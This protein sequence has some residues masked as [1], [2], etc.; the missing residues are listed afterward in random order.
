MLR[1]KHVERGQTTGRVC[2][3]FRGTRQVKN[4]LGEKELQM[5][6]RQT[7]LWNAKAFIL[8]VPNKLAKSEDV[9]EEECGR[10]KDR[11]E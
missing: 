3:R 6:K 2:W 7:E 9:C 11:R 8:M 5:V 1:R 4:D 10:R